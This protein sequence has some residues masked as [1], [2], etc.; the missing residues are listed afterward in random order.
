MFA[1]HVEKNILADV[2]KTGGWDSDYLATFHISR[3]L[4][5][6][7]IPKISHFIPAMVPFK[8]MQNLK[9]CQYK[10]CILYSFYILY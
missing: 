5:S 2:Y 6:Y 3:C 10:I 1:T 7:V 8:N 9:V 4:F